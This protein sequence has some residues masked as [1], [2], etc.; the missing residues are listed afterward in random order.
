MSQILFK[1]RWFAAIFA[2]MTLLSVAIFTGE[3]GQG[4]VLTGMADGLREQREDLEKPSDPVP[5]VLEESPQPEAPPVEFV[6]DE[7]LI[8][9]GDGM[10]NSGDEGGDEDSD[11]EAMDESGD[12]AVV[13]YGD[14]ID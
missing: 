12:G 8:D 5:V 11:G 10:D 9:D 6:P 4:D 13:T 3:G 1:N 7:E 2:G 14:Q